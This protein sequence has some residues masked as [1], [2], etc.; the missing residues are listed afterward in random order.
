MFN[1]RLVPHFTGIAN[2]F[3][4]KERVLSARRIKPAKKNKQVISLAHDEIIPP[5]Q[6]VQYWS[7]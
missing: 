1:V 7:V 4:L 2:G 3:D 6:R 5:D